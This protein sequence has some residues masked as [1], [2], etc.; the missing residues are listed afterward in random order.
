[1]REEVSDGDTSNK[2]RVSLRFI[3][4]SNL[5]PATKSLHLYERA[6]ASTVRTGTSLSYEAY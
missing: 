4:I 2:T 5:K 1:M 6:L 3:Y